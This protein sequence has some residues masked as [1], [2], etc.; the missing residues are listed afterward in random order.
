MREILKT[1][2]GIIQSPIPPIPPPAP[3]ETDRSACST[4]LFCVFNPLTFSQ[5]SHEFCNNYWILSL[6]TMP[7]C[8][9]VKG[10]RRRLSNL[11]QTIGTRSIALSS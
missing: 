6:Q 2:E 7:L 9:G 3:I 1:K 10:N 5:H 8:C 11:A 4:V